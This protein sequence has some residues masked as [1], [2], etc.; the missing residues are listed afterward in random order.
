MEGDK[1]GTVSHWFGKIQVIGIELSGSLVVGDTIHVK[2]HTTDFQHQV[3]S[4]HIY[5]EPVTEA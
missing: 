4:I 3:S 5:S 2:G 1:I